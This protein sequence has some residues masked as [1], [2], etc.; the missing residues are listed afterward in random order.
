[1]VRT[2]ENSQFVLY[3]LDSIRSAANVVLQAEDTGT[4]FK[5]GGGKCYLCE[6]VSQCYYDRKKQIG[7][8]TEELIKVNNENRT[9]RRKVERLEKEIDKRT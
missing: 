4:V 5:D 7:T 2:H 1:M 6:V 3:S 8:L 9:L